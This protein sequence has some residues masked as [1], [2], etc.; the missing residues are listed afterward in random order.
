MNNKLHHLKD[1]TCVLKSYC[2]FLVCFGLT[3]H[4]R[5][6]YRKQTGLLEGRWVGGLG[7]WVMDVKKGT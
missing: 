3:N 1:N 7:N 4:E 5:L 6:N 2:I